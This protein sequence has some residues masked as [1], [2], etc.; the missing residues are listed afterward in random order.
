MRKSTNRRSEEGFMSSVGQPGGNPRVTPTDHQREKSP[1]W[2]QVAGCMLITVGE[3]KNQIKAKGSVFTSRTELTW[4]F[5]HLL[6]AEP[7]T[8]TGFHLRAL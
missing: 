4:F 1:Q 8:H 3:S 2:L 5:K 6:P 7:Q